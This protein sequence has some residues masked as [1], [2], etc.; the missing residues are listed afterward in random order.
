MS[1]P[2]TVLDYG[3]GNQLNVLRALEHCGASVKVVQKASAADVEAVASPC[4]CVWSPLLQLKP[5]HLF[6]N[7]GSLL[8][9]WFC[10]TSASAEVLSLSLRVTVVT[11][12]TFT[13]PQL[14]VMWLFWPPSRPVPLTLPPLMMLM[15][16]AIWF[17]PTTLFK[18][19]ALR[20][21]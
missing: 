3:I 5:T 9:V 13:A 14:W 4:V 6:S 10:V 18:T 16:L 19:N 8:C 12:V 15:P 21:F 1:I 2:V 17:S 11:P 7:V 20:L